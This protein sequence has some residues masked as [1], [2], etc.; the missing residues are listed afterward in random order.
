MQYLQGWIIERRAQFRIQGFWEGFV[1][2]KLLA[3][4]PPRTKAFFYRT[5]AGAEID[6]LLKFRS[7]KSR[8]V[9]IKHGLAP[10]LTRKTHKKTEK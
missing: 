5:N 1:I 7:G 3:C 9:E 8:A 10:D 4:L 2:K 6:L